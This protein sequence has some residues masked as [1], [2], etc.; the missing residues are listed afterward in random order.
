MSLQFLWL[1]IHEIFQL[2]LL[3]LKKQLHC[4][5]QIIHQPPLFQVQNYSSEKKKK[6]GL[7]W[8]KNNDNDNDNILSFMKKKKK[9]KVMLPLW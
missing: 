7:G 5:N 8:G 6:L 4:N 2:H 9:K 3:W 1:Y